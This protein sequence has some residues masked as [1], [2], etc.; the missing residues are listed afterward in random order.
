MI[1]GCIGVIAEVSYEALEKR[2]KQGW[3]CEIVD[4]ADQ[5][6]KRIRDAKDKK[7]VSYLLTYKGNFGFSVFVNRLKNQRVSEGPS[8]LK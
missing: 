6:I 4:D 5:L 8:G 2:H 1:C 3:V 7:E